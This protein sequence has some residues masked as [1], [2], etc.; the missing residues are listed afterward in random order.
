MA[1]AALLEKKKNVR[2]GHKGS[3]TKLIGRINTALAASPADEDKLRQ[4]KLSLTDK[5]QVLKILD[6]DIVDATPE[7]ELAREIEQ[8]DEAREEIHLALTKL[9]RALRPFAPAPPTVVPRTVADP[10]ASIAPIPAPSS[11]AVKLPKLTLQPFNGEMTH[12]TSFWDSFKASV[13][14]NTTL[15]P[16]D[17]FNYL[18]GLLQRSALEAISGLALTDANYP[19]AVSILERRFGNKQQIISKHMDTLIH[20]EAVTSPR[21]GSSPTIR[22]Y[23]V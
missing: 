8:A 15:S 6:D 9:E 23:R 2:R 16:V 20:V 4:L 7:D 11:L 12:W 3:A 22:S 5:L 1:D 13:H 18:R 19:E 17:K 10:V 14:D 21:E